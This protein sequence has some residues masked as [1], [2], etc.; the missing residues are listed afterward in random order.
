M[1]F[2]YQFPMRTHTLTLIASGGFGPELSVALRSASLPGVVLAARTLAALT[3]SWIGRLAQHGAVSLGLA[4]AGDLVN[5]GRA[6]GSLA[7]RGTRQAFLRTLRGVV[8]WSGQRLDATDR[9][10]LLSDL[11]T[12]LITGTRDSCIPHQHTLRAHQAMPGSRLEV[13]LAGHFPHVEYP[14]K[15][16][17]ILLDFLKTSSARAASIHAAPPRLECTA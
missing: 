4:P 7:D 3:P 9:L 13:L 6:L 17:K 10:D 15:I 2:A 8:G 14:D 11:P 1:M 12:L 16:A 5:L